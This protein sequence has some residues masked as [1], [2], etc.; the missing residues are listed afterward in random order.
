MNKNILVIGSTGQLGTSLLKYCH[1]NQL[2]ISCITCFKNKTKLHNQKKR[3]KVI[4]SFCLNDKYDASLFIKYLTKTKFKIIYFLDYGY[5][6]LRYLDIILNNNKNCFMAIANKELLI[7]GG[8][9]LLKK[10]NSTKNNLVPLDSEHF[11]LLKSNI[12]NKNI[13]KVFITASG[14]PFYFDKKID[15]NSVNIKQ[16]LKHPKWKMGVNNTIDS[17]NFINKILEI[18][19]LSIIFNINLDRIHFLVSREAYVHSVVLFEDNTVVFNCFEN[20]M[21]LTLIK[22][23]TQIFDSKQLNIKSDKYLNNIN[24]K[25]EEFSDNRFKISKYMNKLIKLNHNQ[26]IKFM[27]LNNIAHKRYLEGNLNYNDI[28]DFIMKK[29]YLIDLDLS[30]NSIKNILIYADSIKSKYEI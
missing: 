25:I 16:V 8:R 29:I 17:S 6:S 27:I 13:K 18:Y 2:K 23:L 7:A 28:I 30:L 21:L 10:I 3:N 5:Q 1:T 22:P 4:N 14:G 26:Q 19:E 20:I 24:F 11:S 9:T 12:S 15:L